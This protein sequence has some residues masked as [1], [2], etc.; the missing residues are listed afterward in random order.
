MHQN[1]ING[2]KYIVDDLKSRIAG[3]STI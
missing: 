2:L 3:D 1:S